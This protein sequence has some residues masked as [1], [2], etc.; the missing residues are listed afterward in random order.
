MPSGSPMSM[1]I[2]SEINVNPMCWI[3][4]CSS[5]PD[6]CC[7]NSQRLSCCSISF[8]GLE[9]IECADESWIVARSD[10]FCFELKTLLLQE[11]AH[12]VATWLKEELVGCPLLYD[13]AFVH[14]E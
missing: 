3:V 14:Q 7:M 12:I 4:C 5:L 13:P 1:A 9:V 2:D 10:A 8:P 6:C 11:L